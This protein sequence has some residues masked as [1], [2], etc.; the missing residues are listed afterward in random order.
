[1]VVNFVTLLSEL[2][3]RVMNWFHLDDEAARWEGDMRSYLF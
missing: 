2:A 3:P 1:M